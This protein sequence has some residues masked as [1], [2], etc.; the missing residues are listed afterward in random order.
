MPHDVPGDLAPDAVAVPH[1]VSPV[2]SRPHARMDD[3]RF[4]MVRQADPGD[5][6]VRLNIVVNWLEE[7]KERTR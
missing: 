3:Q 6:T 2:R 7:L 4:L 5:S 1:G